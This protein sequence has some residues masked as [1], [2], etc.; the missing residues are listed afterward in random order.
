MDIEDIE[1]KIMDP[2]NFLKSDSNPEFK[3]FKKTPTT[4]NFFPQRGMNVR[5]GG[6]D[7]AKI[8]MDFGKHKGKPV[9]DVIVNDRQYAEWYH[10]QESAKKNTHV[11]AVLEKEFGL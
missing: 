5:G 10:S 2:S 7:P 3:R 4:V 1:N 9:Q 11:Y 8:K 6:V